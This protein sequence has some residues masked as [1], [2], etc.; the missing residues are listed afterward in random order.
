LAKACRYEQSHSEQVAKLSL[1]IFDQLKSDGVVMK[2]VDQDAPEGE[3]NK[4]SIRRGGVRWG[5]DPAERTILE[6]AGV[7][8]DVGI[9]VEYRRHH[10]HSATIVRHADLA[11]WSDR[12]REVLAQA[13]R[14]HRR[15]EPSERHEEFGALGATERGLVQ[16]IAAVLRIADGLDRS[17]TRVVQEVRVRK[18]KQ[19]LM[20]AVHASSHAHE[21]RRAAGDK[22]G[23]LESL[24]GMSIEIEL[25]RDVPVVE[26]IPGALISKHMDPRHVRRRGRGR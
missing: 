21:E 4:G 17:H 10:K 25:E 23:L 22:G 6:A 18:G 12:D 26:T 11:H 5:S 24:I 1:Q 3:G 16:R 14:Y 7:L 20:L 9:M 19:S 8:H 2:F 15:S 13:C